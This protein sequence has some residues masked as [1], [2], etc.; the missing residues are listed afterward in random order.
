VSG[1]SD[2]SVLHHQ[3]DLEALDES[4]SEHHQLIT[5]ARRLLLDGL[6]VTPL[7]SL[8]SL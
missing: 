4:S 3:I 2:S 1:L 6:V 7:R 5:L 8:K